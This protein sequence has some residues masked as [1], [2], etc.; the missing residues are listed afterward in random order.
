MFLG[1]VMM[2]ARM[3]KMM[4]LSLKRVV[5]EDELFRNWQYGLRL[6]YLSGL[7]PLCW[8]V[9]VFSLLIF[10]QTRHTLVDYVGCYSK[11][12]DGIRG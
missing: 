11:L 6:W 12:L 1:F 10:L 7:L 5:F 4:G 3:F 2:L 9:S 8:M